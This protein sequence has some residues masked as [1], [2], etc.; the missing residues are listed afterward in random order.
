[1]DN[2]VPMTQGF[3]SHLIDPAQKNKDWIASYIKAAWKNFSVYYPRQLY[4][5]REEYHETRLYMLGRQSISRYKRL[6]NPKKV[7]NED[8]SNVNIDWNVLPIIPKFRRI[9]L[10]TLIKTDY[11]IAIDAIDPLAQDDKESFY[12]DNAAKILVKKEYEKAGLDPSL[13]PDPD[14]EAS[15][16]KELDMYM[17][18]SYKHRMAIEME[19]AL[20][21]LFNANKL[22][23]QRERCIED[24]FDVG[25]TGFKDYVETASGK[26]RA[27]RV[28]PANILVSYT[29]DPDF[30]DIQYAGEVIEM[31]ISDLKARAGDQISA[32][33]Y[34][35]IATEYTNKMGNTGTF[36]NSNSNQNRNFD[37]FRIKVLE[38]EF[39]SVN[40]YIQEE[41]IN[42]KGNLVVGK[43]K[44]IKEGKTDKKF[45]SR[46]VKVV[47]KGCWVIDSNV[48][49]DCGLA[50]NMKRAVSDLSNTYLSY[51][52]VAP[53]IYQMTTY[54]IGKHLKPIA[55]QIQL[56]WLKLQNTIMK[57]RPRGI[58][59]EI[60]AIEDVP[61]GKAGKNITPGQIIDLYNET[62]NLVYR[63]K[64]QDGNFS[65]YSP[66][67]ELN[68]G[69]GQEAREYFGI[70]NNNIQLLRD[71]LGFN[72]ITDGSTPDPR[73]LKGVASLAS[74][75]TNNSLDYIKRAERSMMESLS[76]SLLM[77]VQDAAISGDI[78]SFMRSLGS[79]SIEFFKLDPN[80][81]AYECG[82][83][84]KEKP[85]K[86]EEERLARRIEQAVQSGQITLADA[87]A[88][89][90]LDNVK[91]AEVLLA[92][93]ISKNEEEKQ[94]RAIEL[95]QQN[96]NIQQ[97]SAMVSAQAKQQE[98][99]LES[100]SKINEI[101]A[102][103][104]VDALLLQMK[105]AL[106][107]EI[108][109]NKAEKKLTATEIE[110]K[111]REYIQQIKNAGAKSVV[112]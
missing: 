63:R 106:T 111:S 51:H 94:K 14:V 41:R 29:T 108:E 103:G 70:I 2:N 56:A 79:G 95:Q 84:I 25:C 52:I 88:I 11:D 91:Y 24:L 16:I 36:N 9:A 82:L 15:S 61:L 77:R 101:K 55:D 85:S 89:E 12:A 18:Y 60:G 30:K 39:Y 87:I 72:E 53:G 33:D 1:M 107:A 17:M 26:I 71:I 80:T 58:K 81:S 4:N 42:S 59:I 22:G 54:S 7:A 20:K 40:K 23:N 37:G 92:Y 45:T 32:D 6:F 110:A 68:N 100:Q 31:T 3:P 5:G 86:I 102:Q 50:T 38:L 99:V 105:M 44:A 112:K 74:E 109:A 47:Y 43:A 34:E 104:E 90:N 48:F 96:G 66:I 35:R 46:D 28:D 13:V 10:S 67:E 69:I 27:R 83:V 78:N 49:F 21:V 8:Q 97:Q 73:T 65:S 76:N 75:S 62:G 93:R 98:V 19:M 64:D 57:A